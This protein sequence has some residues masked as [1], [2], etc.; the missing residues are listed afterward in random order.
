ME[1]LRKV[2][3]FFFVDRKK[4][5]KKSDQ[6]MKLITSAHVRTVFS[7]ISFGLALAELEQRNEGNRRIRFMSLML[8]ERQFFGSVN[9]S[10]KLFEFP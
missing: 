2:N 1:F 3:Y 6:T 4:K 7:S 10:G 9:F 8:N 5:K